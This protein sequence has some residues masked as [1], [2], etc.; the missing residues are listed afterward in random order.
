MSLNQLTSLT[1]FFFY[2]LSLWPCGLF[3]FS[4]R[5]L[6]FC[7]PLSFCALTLFAEN[8]AGYDISRGKF[9]PKKTSFLIL[10][11]YFASI[12]HVISVISNLI[13]V[14]SF[15]FLL[16]NFWF[17]NCS[18]LFIFNFLFIGLQSNYGRAMTFPTYLQIWLSENDDL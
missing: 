15:R 18:F 16:F 5:F 11:F 13:A 8:V 7:H 17:Y 12:F 6:G 4:S 3:T 2:F 1:R 14:V 10:K 9:K